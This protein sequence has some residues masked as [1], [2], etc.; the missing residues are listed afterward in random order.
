METERQ[1]VQ[2]SATQIREK[3]QRLLIDSQLFNAPWS[4]DYITQPPRHQDTHLP[5][6]HVLGPNAFNAPFTLQKTGGQ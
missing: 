4:L 6:A 1:S 2:L 5:P 3:A